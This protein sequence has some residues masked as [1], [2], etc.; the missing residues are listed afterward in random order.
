[1]TMFKKKTKVHNKKDW[2]FWEKEFD[3]EEVKKHL[4][5]GNYSARSLELWKS[6]IDFFKNKK[7]EYTL[8]VFYKKKE[9][10]YA[11]GYTSKKQYS[12]VVFVDNIIEAYRKGDY[13]AV[14]HFHNHPTPA[15][16]V[17][18]KTTGNTFGHWLDHMFPSVS[19]FETD[20]NVRGLLKLDNIRYHGSFIITKFSIAR[21]NYPDS[22]DVSSPYKEVQDIIERSFF[23]LSDLE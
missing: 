9:P 6:L 15:W 11:L 12:T 23:D 1:M 13:D 16:S 14:A 17:V 8:V 19:D 5:L 7:T 10:K 18:K 22:Y 20:R 2:I 3:S 21:Y 4:N